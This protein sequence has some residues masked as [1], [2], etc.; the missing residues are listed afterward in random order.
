[1][2]AAPSALPN[3]D[4]APS[5]SGEDTLLAPTTWT[6][7]KRHAWLLGSWFPRFPSSAGASSS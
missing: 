4:S 3:T 7:P 6:D 5:H 2:S 1:M